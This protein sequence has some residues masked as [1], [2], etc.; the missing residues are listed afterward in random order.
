MLI[1]NVLSVMLFIN[2][3]R[4]TNPSLSTSRYVILNPNFSN[5]WQLFNIAGCS[6]FDV[7]I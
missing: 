5:V 3:S 7:I 6:I 4:F 2:V 1:K